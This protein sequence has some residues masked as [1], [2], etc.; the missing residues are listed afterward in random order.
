MRG[1]AV[2]SGVSRETPP[3]D[4][5]GLVDEHPL[6]RPAPP[7]RPYVSSYAGYRQAGVPPGR[8][9]GL[10]SPRLTLIFT[11]DEPPGPRHLRRPHR[12]SA[13]R[14]RADH[15]PGPSVRHPGRSAPAGRPRVAGAARRRAGKHR[16]SRGGGARAAGHGPRGTA[17]DGPQLA[18]AVCAAGRLS[19]AL[20]VAG[21]ARHRRR[22]GAGG[23][24][25]LAVAGPVTGCRTGGDARRGHRLEHPPSDRPFPAGNRS[26]AQDR[27]AGHPLRPGTPGAR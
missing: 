27:R 6:T 3:R 5:P 10:P 26:D 7:L 9:R 11:L 14:P 24:P 25:C 12:R 13:H 17:A 4:R 2:R 1:R 20:P 22:S 16:P 8:H 18:G 15:P 19:A 23:R 21:T